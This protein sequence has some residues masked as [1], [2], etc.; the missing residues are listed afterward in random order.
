M[1]SK[2]CLVDMAKQTQ[3]SNQGYVLVPLPD[4]VSLSYD[5]KFFLDHTVSLTYVS[6]LPLDRIPDAVLCMILM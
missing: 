6:T 5:S 3:L 1:L 2:Q 4:L